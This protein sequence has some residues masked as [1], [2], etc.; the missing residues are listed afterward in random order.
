M[1]KLSFGIVFTV[2]IFLIGCASALVEYEW[3]DRQRRKNSGPKKKT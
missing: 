3:E 1:E 2:V